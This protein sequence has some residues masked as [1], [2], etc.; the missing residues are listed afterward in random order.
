MALYIKIIVPKVAFCA[1]SGDNYGYTS[2][3]DFMLP[4]ILPRIGQNLKVTLFPYDVRN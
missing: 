3:S 2:K 1:F 4:A